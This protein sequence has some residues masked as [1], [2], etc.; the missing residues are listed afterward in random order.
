MNGR[1]ERE[2]V[3]FQIYLDDAGNASEKR[4]HEDKNN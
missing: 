4:K 2:E 1:K 3:N